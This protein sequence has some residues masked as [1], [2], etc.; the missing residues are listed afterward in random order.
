MIAKNSIDQVLSIAKVEDVISDFVNLK[1]S[2]SNLLGLCPFHHEKTP[3]FS[4]SP[5]KNIYKC[6]GCSKAGGPLQFVMEHENLSYPEGIRYLARKYNVTLEE[7]HD[8]KSDEQNQKELQEESYHIINEAAA[9]IYQ[10]ALY[11]LPS[12]KNIGLAY[13]KERGFL[14][15]TIQAFGLGFAPDQR[16]YV[17]R[18]LTDQGF[19]IAKLEELGL[20]NAQKNDFFQNRVI[21]PIH[22]VVGKVIAFSGR[23]MGDGE[24]GPK[25]INSRET[26]LY[27]K[28][29]VLY[30][31]HLAKQSIRAK[32]ECLLVE[33]Y[34]DVISLYQAG[35]RHVVASSGTALTEDQIRLIRRFTENVKI[36]YDGDSAGVKAS[37][38]ALEMFLEEGLNVFLVALPSPEDPDSFVTK[39]GSS[40]AEEFFKTRAEDFILFKSRQIQTETVQN[41]I[42]K[43][44]GIQE[45]IR[46]I[47]KIPNA[48]KR[49]AYIQSCAAVLEISEEI[50]LTEINRGVKKNIVDKRNQLAKFESN[51]GDVEAIHHPTGSQSPINQN[52]AVESDEAQEYSVIRVLV[53]FGHEK[54]DEY[55]TVAQYIIGEIEELLEEFTNPLY[56]KIMNEYLHEIS[57]GNLITTD[58]FLKHENADIRNLIID[59]VQSPFTYSPNWSTRWEMELQTQP[60]PE[61]NFK[62]DSH[63]SILRFKLKKIQNQIRENKKQIEADNTTEYD[64]LV[65]IKTQ[66]ELMKYRNQLADLLG[67]RVLI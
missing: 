19:T 32:N 6:F 58:Y 61:K 42:K 11:Q 33:G 24:F 3:S 7:I 23:K 37:S 29:K 30:G 44:E 51:V 48:I 59:M 40:Y 13:F 1:R 16:D 47:S 63:E 17:F 25:Y 27:I 5:S 28:S 12:G 35:I 54:M 45:I 18:K 56:Q 14:D 26:P 60:M 21:F 22:S 49:T 50:L 55:R 65:L 39:N 4:V 53:L 66:S 36:I 38:R 43:S 62:A 15:Q 31:I 9:K 52:S 8:S 20:L 46:L 64:Q 41:P 10:E 34:T 2:G 67:M 57:D